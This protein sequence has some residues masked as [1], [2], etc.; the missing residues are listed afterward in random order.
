MMQFITDVDDHQ[1]SL[2]EVINKIND[3]PMLPDVAKEMLSDLNNDDISLDTIVEKVAL[4]QALAAKVLRLA[5]SS[6]YG[7]NSKVVTIQQAVAMLGIKNLKNLI[8]LSIFTKH[9]PHAACRAGAQNPGRGDRGPDPA[10]RGVRV[11]GR[12]LDDLSRRGR[13]TAL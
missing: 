9:L 10:G 8:R 13:L 4:D 6:I 5:N 3:L 7:A 2:E 1:I 11:S 12:R